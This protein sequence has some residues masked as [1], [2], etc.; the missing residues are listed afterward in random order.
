MPVGGTDYEAMLHAVLDAFSAGG[1]ADRYLIVLSDGESQTDDLAGPR[2]RPAQEKHPRDRPRRRH[3]AGRVHPRRVGRLRE[4]RARRRRAL[5]AQQLHAAGARLGH[6]RR[7][8]RRQRVGRPRRAAQTDGRGRPPRRVQGAHPGAAAGALPVGAGARAALPAAQP[9]ARIPGA[10]ARAQPAAGSR[11]R[12]ADTRTGKPR[13]AGAAERPPRRCMSRWP[14]CRCS[15]FRLVR[16]RGHLGL[17]RAAQQAGRTPLG[18]AGARPP[19]TMPRWRRR[20]S[21]G[22]GVCRKPSS[23]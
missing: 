8:H 15:G 9:L 5:Q 7:V 3:R 6:Q 23:R 18:A 20:P 14:V 11:Y 10:A 16:R 19:A 21:R 4:G 22:D 1:T 12:K 13:L 17:R 2:R